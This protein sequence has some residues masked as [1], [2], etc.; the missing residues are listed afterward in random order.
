[1]LALHV[2]GIAICL[3]LP[4]KKG[5]IGLHRNLWNTFIKKNM[6]KRIQR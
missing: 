3:C 4:E 5:D 2:H 1:M 6:E